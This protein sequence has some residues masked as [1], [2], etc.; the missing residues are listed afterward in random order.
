M[1]LAAPVSLL[2]VSGISVPSGLLSNLLL[3]LHFIYFSENAANGRE[4]YEWETC[5]KFDP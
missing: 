2:R 4:E 1:T 3:L 5:E